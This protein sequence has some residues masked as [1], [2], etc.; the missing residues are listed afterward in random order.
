[1][2]TDQLMCTAAPT[3]TLAL[4]P[5]AFVPGH[6][7][8]VFVA[9][10]EGAT[11]AEFTLKAGAHDT[12]KVRCAQCCE[13]QGATLCS[14]NARPINP[15]HTHPHTHTHPI[16]HHPPSSHSHPLTF[17]SRAHTDS[18]LVRRCCSCFPFL[19]LLTLIH[20]SLADAA[21]ASHHVGARLLLSRARDAHS[22]VCVCVCEKERE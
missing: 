4:G 16:H 20:L 11:W 14:F 7:E 10:P 5:L 8:R 18:S 1:M 15:P 3:P 22:G 9:V 12:P 17:P 13:G 6:E 2:T 19:F 21:P